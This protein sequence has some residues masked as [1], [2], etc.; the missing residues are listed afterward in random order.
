MFVQQSVIFDTGRSKSVPKAYMYLYSPVT[1]FTGKQLI[2]TF[3]IKFIDSK[4]YPGL[5]L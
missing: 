1:T 3:T 4:T 5:N 2:E